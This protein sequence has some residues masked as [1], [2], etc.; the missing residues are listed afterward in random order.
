MSYYYISNPYN[1]SDSQKEM[2]AKIAAQV[3]GKLLKRGVHAWSPIVHNHAMMSDYGGFT[4][5]ERRTLILDFD[6]SLLLASKGMIVL[7]ID[8][9]QES[10]G[11]S[12][13]VELCKEK[14]I[15]VQYLNPLDLDSGKSIEEILHN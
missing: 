4:L 14:S 7:K 15:S 5:D 11:V 10:Y 12:K 1:G 3:C 2:R 6:F 8:G 13:E 9:W